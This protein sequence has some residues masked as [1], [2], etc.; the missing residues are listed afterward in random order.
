[1]LHLDIEPK[2]AADL[3]KI[4]SLAQK[5]A[6]LRT[7]AEKQAIT[8]TPKEWDAVQAGA[9]SNHMLV[10]ILKNADLDQVKG[11]ANPRAT[12][13]MLPAKIARAQAMLKT[14]HTQAEIADQLGISTSVLSAALNEN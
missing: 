4:R 12:T 3:K 5:D 7:G 11:L 14:G 2:R 10:N 6:R 1:M 8:F 13:T 9:I